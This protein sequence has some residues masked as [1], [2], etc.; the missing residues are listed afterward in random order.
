MLIRAIEEAQ[1]PASERM[2]AEE[3][4]MEMAEHETNNIHSQ[5]NRLTISHICSNMAPL[6]GK[7]KLYKVVYTTNTS[8]LIK[9]I[10]RAENAQSAV[11][12]SLCA[13]KSKPETYQN[14]QTVKEVGLK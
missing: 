11:F 3:L 4:G 13:L 8:K 2:S 9:D 7:N 6:E 10:V 14:I 12:R 1:K 5:A